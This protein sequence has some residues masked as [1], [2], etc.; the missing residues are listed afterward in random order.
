[1]PCSRMTLMF[2]Y[3]SAS[4]EVLYMSPRGTRDIY[5]VRH[6]LMFDKRDREK[7]RKNKTE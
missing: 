4:E 1:M 5:I 7:A 6:G 3:S 2:D